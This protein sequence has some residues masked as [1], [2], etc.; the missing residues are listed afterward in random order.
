MALFWAF[1]FYWILE[2]RA[3][4]QVR[5]GI[6][7]RQRL[8]V[9]CGLGFVGAIV[10]ALG[11]AAAIPQTAT[12][13]TAS[14][15][16]K[17]VVESNTAFALD[18]YQKLKEKPGNLF[19]SPYSI[20]SALAMTC[21]G[22]RNQT[23]REMAGALHFNLPPTNLAEVF[24]ALG[25]RMKKVQR[26]DRITLTTANS[27]WCQ[28]DY[29][30]SKNF[31]DLVSLRYGGEARQV[32][33]RNSAQAAGTEMNEWVEQRTKGKIKG[34]VGPGQL[35]ANTRLILCNAIY[36]KGKWQNQFKTG[37][38]KPMNFDVNTNQSVTVPMM[39][40][41][42]DFKMTHN[43]DDTVEMLELPYSGTDLSMIIFLPAAT[44]DLSGVEHFSLPD[45]ERQLTIEHLHAWMAMLDQARLEETWVALPRFTTALTFDLA[46]ELKSLGMS[47]AFNSSADF[48][49]M[50]ATTNLFITGVIQKAFVEV[51]ETGTEAAAVTWVQAKTKGMTRSFRADHPFIFL[52][53]ENGSGTI[54]FIGRM[55]DPTK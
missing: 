14:P 8:I 52:I 23:E 11:I 45:L 51:N 9:R 6:S 12:R 49:G 1:L 31:L 27:L 47:S 3:C 28:R 32:D 35:T 17:S 5:L 20:S 40:Q 46:D 22:A 16:V 13:F 30:F 48:S 38:T 18:L 2:V 19:F 7:P 15:A 41:K 24:G 50:E 33:F 26:W 21:A 29:Q 34:A 54:L 55:I 43:D 10:L 25:A 53:R 44:R 37:D 39:R 36:F 42:S 4:L